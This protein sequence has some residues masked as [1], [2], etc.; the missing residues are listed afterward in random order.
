MNHKKY[1]DYLLS[2]A[3]IFLILFGITVSA[4]AQNTMNVALCPG[5]SFWYDGQEYSTPGTYTVAG[6]GDDGSTVTL[7]ITAGV[8]P[9]ITVGDDKYV[10][11][12]DDLPIQISAS[13]GGAG[14]SYSWSTGETSSSILI[15]S[16]GTYAVTVTNAAGCVGSDELSVDVMDDL[17]IEI[18]A[19]SDFCS[20]GSTVL[21]ANTNASDITWNTGETTPEIDIKSYGRYTV[22]AHSGTCRV[23]SVI[24]IGPCDFDLYFPNAIT[25]SNPDGL[26]DEFRVANPEGIDEF[27]IFIYDRWGYLVYHSTDPHFSWNGT[28][29]GKIATN[30][31]FSWRAF[32]KPFTEDKK[33][34]F[35]GSIFVF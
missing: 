32:A 18:T 14:A 11:S 17:F 8:A 19:T 16:E 1:I 35:N 21:V 22:S 33:Y 5:E 23:S 12:A 2:I 30:N 6:H 20:N 27:E 26:N 29:Q 34:S 7:V 13:G 25:P 28:H 24:D 3:V 31:I 4:S 15:Y 9:N 10:C